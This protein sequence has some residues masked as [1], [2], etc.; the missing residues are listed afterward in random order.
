MPMLCSILMKLGV[1]LPHNYHNYLNYFFINIWKVSN[2][3]LISNNLIGSTVFQLKVFLIRYKQICRVHLIHFEKIFAVTL[4]LSNIV[5][6][7]PNAIS[8]NFLAILSK[9]WWLSIRLIRSTQLEAISKKS[10][11]CKEGFGKVLVGNI[12]NCYLISNNLIGSTVF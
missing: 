5:K 6:R 4:K 9:Y 10:D 7:C 1:E 12:W 2:C 8:A 11:N 3:N